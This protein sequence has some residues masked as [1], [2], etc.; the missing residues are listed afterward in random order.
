MISSMQLQHMIQ[1]FKSLRFELDNL[2]KY[3]NTCLLNVSKLYNCIQ[4]KITNTFH[5]K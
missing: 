4:Y 3:A 2:V 1:P 5:F